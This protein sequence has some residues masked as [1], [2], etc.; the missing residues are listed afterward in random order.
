VIR[1]FRMLKKLY[2][3]LKE[4]EAGP[5]KLQ[6]PKRSLRV[7]LWV[8]VGHLSLQR[9]LYL[10]ALTRPAAVALQ[11]YISSLYN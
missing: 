2:N 9:L 4:A 3:Y 6:Q 5:Q 7:V 11:L 1:R 8:L 10:L